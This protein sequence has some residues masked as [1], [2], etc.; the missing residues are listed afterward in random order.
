MFPIPRFSTKIEN[1]NHVEN[2]TL[3]KKTFG[4]FSWC[5]KLEIYFPDNKFISYIC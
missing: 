2:D 4:Y 1:D 5:Q 3:L